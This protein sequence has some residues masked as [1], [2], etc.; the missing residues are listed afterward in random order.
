MKLRLALMLIAL[1]GCQMRDAASSAGLSADG[2][3]L[4]PAGTALR[5]DFGRAQDGVIDS[6]SELIGAAPARLGP[7]PDCG[8]EV[9]TAEWSAGLSLHF[10]SGDFRGWT[11]A[12]PGIEA[13]GLTVGARLDAGAVSGDRGGIFAEPTPD[14]T[15]IARLRAGL[16][17]GSA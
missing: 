3:G 2:G 11:L 16:P 4:Q 7:N 6:V 17:C 1:A 14:G 13:S 15:R 5:I 8:A 9:I 12:A 10:R